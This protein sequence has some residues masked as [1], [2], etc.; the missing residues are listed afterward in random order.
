MQEVMLTRDEVAKRLSVTPSGVAGL[1]KRKACPLEPGRQVDGVRR[2]PESEVLKTRAWLADQSAEAPA[3]TPILAARAAAKTIAEK[4]NKAKA[5]AA[6]AESSEAPTEGLKKAARKAKEAKG[7]KKAKAEKRAKTIAVA[8]PREAAKAEA[9]PAAARAP[10]RSN[11]SASKPAAKRPSKTD[12]AKQP[13]AAAL[14]EI[15]TPGRALWSEVAPLPFDMSPARFAMVAAPPVPPA[16]AA[17]MQAAV[18]Q[19]A[20]VIRETARRKPFGPATDFMLMGPMIVLNAMSAPLRAMEAKAAD[21]PSIA[22]GDAARE[23]AALYAMGRSAA[24]AS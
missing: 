14:P 18:R 19:M 17:P 22:S 5:R 1:V 2:W 13:I 4:R 15:E 8:A 11:K 12:G 10:A 3:A 9:K 16:L 7:A 24:A 21:A 6:A 23:D 20:A